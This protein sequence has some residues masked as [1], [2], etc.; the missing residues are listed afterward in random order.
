MLAKSHLSYAGFFVR[1]TLTLYAGFV[2]GVV[3]MIVIGRA[4]SFDEGVLAFSRP[5]D[6]LRA[7]D[8]LIMDVRTRRM[9][10]V[11]NYGW[12]V[13][14]D[15]QWSP[16]GRYLAL[17]TFGQQ[18]DVYVVDVYGGKW[19]NITRDFASDR[20][21]SWSPDGQQ[22]AFFSTRGDGLQFDIYLV[23]PDGSNLRR[24]TYSESSYPAW[25]PDGTQLVFS[26][27]VDG[28]LYITGMNG[29]SAKQLTDTPG[30]DRN[31][32]W[33][34][35]GSQ[36]AYISFVNRDGIFGDRIFVMN[37]DGSENR[38]LS[39]EFS[40]QGM[41]SWS[42]KSR[43]LAFIGRSRGERHDSLYLADTFDEDHPIR[44]L[45]ENA[46]YAYS[47]RWAMW[48]P[49]GRYLA[50]SS[51]DANGLYTVDVSSGHIREL[52]SLAIMYP[53]WQPRANNNGSF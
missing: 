37:A 14:A 7:W 6:R 1:F 53:V 39:R 27:R 33:S 32:V 26:S 40:A 15:L 16:D 31:P 25:S 50:F 4:E 5:T 45:A 35:D 51:R 11:M 12:R 8:V 21:P 49:D 44:K 47:E 10:E 24:L 17:A 29:T 20:Y 41:P 28:D 52:A 18:S 48:S 13:A 19:H 36:I 9:V 3:A 2:L 22:L 46:Y 42:P 38:L 30:D 43:Y 34:P 23:N